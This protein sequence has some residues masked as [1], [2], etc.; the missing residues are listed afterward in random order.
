M[1]LALVFAAAVQC[2]DGSPPPCARAAAAHTAPAI[3]QRRIAI[4]P[5]R[6]TATDTLYG[7]GI[8]ELLS[9]Q[10]GTDD[11]LRAAHMGTVLRAWRRAGGSMQTPLDQVAVHRVARELGAGRIVDGSIVSLGPRLTL[12][13]SLTTMPAGTSRRVGPFSGPADSLEAMVG[14]LAAGLLGAADPN[15]VDLQT[16]M[17]DSPDAMRA[18][19]EGLAHFRARD[20]SSAGSAFERAFGLDSTFARAA[21]MRYITST[22]GWNAGSLGTW[23]QHVF[24]LYPRLSSPDQIL[25]SALLGEDGRRRTP[26]QHLAD[27]ERAV[28][29]LPENPEALY[30]LGDF[31][32]HGGATLGRSRR[33]LFR[34]AIEL[35]ERSIALDTQATVVQHLL[36]AALLQRDTARLSA[37]WP[38]LDRL[39]SGA[40]SPAPLYGLLISEISGDAAPRAAALRRAHD[41]GSSYRSYAA[42]RLYYPALGADGAA[43]VYNAF[44]G[45]ASP[46]AA[47]ALWAHSLV[48]TG[49]PREL[50]EL[51]RTATDSGTGHYLDYLLV[52]SAAIGEVD[53][54]VATG[55]LARLRSG[56][57]IAEGS[58]G[59]H[60]QCATALWDQRTGPARYD[61]ATVTRWLP[62]CA[63]ALAL[64]EAWRSRAPDVDRRVSMF[65]SLLRDEIV[66]IGSAQWWENRILARVHEERGNRRAAL[67]AIRLRR[68]AFGA[69]WTDAGD[70]RIEGRL[71]ALQGDTA[72]AI[73][74][75]QRYLNL[76]RDAEPSLIPQRDSV[77]SALNALRRGI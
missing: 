60:I 32:F 11:Q 43:R 65:D 53:T 51:R 4:L 39:T 20:L 54:V 61:S 64:A 33:E 40:N 19:L 23:S 55:A 45:Q 71:A 74:S 34:Q 15:R 22:W 8:A 75:Y 62:T 48:R 76:R 56:A 38:V 3:D 10:V 7:A 50:V 36:D 26:S 41:I 46:P 13:A 30:Q 66:N 14:R 17:T 25:V 2:P 5:F 9:S 67:E 24:R 31:L 57:A 70:L 6:V 59:A 47:V 28:A 69:K 1:I 12:T 29:L 37:W 63:A 27:R 42:G 21:W 52:I 58:D 77:Q 44:A 72:D 18:Y 16:R 35:F 73:E 49:R 68:Y